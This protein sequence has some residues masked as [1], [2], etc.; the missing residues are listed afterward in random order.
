MRAFREGTSTTNNGAACSFEIPANGSHFTLRASAPEAPA[1]IQASLVLVGQSG[2]TELYVGALKRAVTLIELPVTLP[3]LRLVL[4][5]A[6]PAC[7][8]FEIAWV[9]HGP[10]EEVDRCAR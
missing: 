7:V 8:A 6:K 3:G 4:R 2:E 1:P 9:Q 10:V 5:P